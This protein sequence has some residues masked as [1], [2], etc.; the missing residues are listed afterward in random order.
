MES[1]EDA[2]L[3]LE[4]STPASRAS[5]HLI[6]LPH[7]PFE[8]RPRNELLSIVGCSYVDSCSLTRSF[9]QRHHPLWIT[10]N[11]NE[12]LWKP[13]IAFL[14]SSQLDTLSPT[15]TA[16]LRVRDCATP[17]PSALHPFCSGAAPHNGCSATQQVQRPTTGAALRNGC[18]ATQRVHHGTKPQRKQWPTTEHNTPPHATTTG[19]TQAAVHPIRRHYTPSVRVQRPATGSAPHNGC[20]APQRMPSERLVPHATANMQR[21]QLPNTR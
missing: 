12:G 11:T 3:Q 10:D 21:R 15:L 16:P 14:S 20:S 8:T 6:P 13:R 4:R 1:Q 18:S 5:K 7:G 2:D 9:H 19:T 17:D